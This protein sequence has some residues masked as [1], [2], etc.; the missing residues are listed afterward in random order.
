MQRVR[1]LEVAV[2]IAI[3]LCRWSMREL[4]TAALVGVAS[5][6]LIHR[7]FDQPRKQHGRERFQAPGCVWCLPI[8]LFLGSDGSISS[9]RYGRVVARQRLPAGPLLPFGLQ[10]LNPGRVFEQLVAACVLVCGFKSTSAPP[11]RER[12][13]NRQTA[14]IAPQARTYVCARRRNET[15]R[16]NPA[17]TSAAVSSLT[18]RKK[19]LA[20]SYPTYI[21]HVLLRLFS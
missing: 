1:Y 8:L 11:T 6:H 2:F 21:L 18:R 7:L 19:K 17:R 4:Y 16:R 5:C 10:P 15:N 13:V 12:P 9:R 3:F 20:L 14:T